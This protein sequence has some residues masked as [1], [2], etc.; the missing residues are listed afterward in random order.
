[1]AME[2]D[3]PTDWAFWDRSCRAYLTHSH[4]V[5]VLKLAGWDRSSGVAAEVRIA[6]ELGIPIEYLEP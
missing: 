5:V 1:M 3:L 4:K 2:V 6:Q